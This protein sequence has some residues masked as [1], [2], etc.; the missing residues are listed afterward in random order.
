MRKYWLVFVLSFQSFLEYR[1]DLLWRILGTLITTLMLYVFWTAVLGT[2][3]GRDK[4]TTV[5]LGL[6][7]LLISFVS[8]TT[9]FSFRDVED[10][11]RAVSYT[12]LTLPTT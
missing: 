10:D 12:H 3:F 1:V 2:G 4:Y 5:S 7:Y 8:M 11:I 9:V 6:Y